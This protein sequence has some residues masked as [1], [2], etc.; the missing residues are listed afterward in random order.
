MPPANVKADLSKTDAEKAEA[1]GRVA[2][3]PPMHFF[4]ARSAAKQA[5]LFSRPICHNCPAVVPLKSAFL[6]LCRAKPLI[7]WWA[8]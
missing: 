7:L 4:A 1:N 6:G 5:V 3:Y 8:Q 2:M